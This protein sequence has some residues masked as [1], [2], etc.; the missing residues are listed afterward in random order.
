[1]RT[2]P[3]GGAGGAGLA[4]AALGAT[5]GHP[6][7]EGRVRAR[8]GGPARARG[9]PA[10]RGG[11]PPRRRHLHRGRG[12]GLLEALEGRRAWPRPKPPLPAAVGLRGRPT[13]VQNVE[14][15]CARA[16]GVARSRRVPARARRRSSRCGAHVH[17]PGVYE[18]PLG[19]P[20]R[21]VVDEW[22]GG[23]TDG[24][25]PAVPRR[26]VGSAADRGQADL[27]LDPDALRAAGSGL[28]TAALLVHR[29]RGAAPSAVAASAR[30]RSSSARLRPVPA[31]H[32]RHRQPGRDVRA[33]GGGD[34][35][36]PATCATWPRRPA[37]CRATATARTAARRRPRSAASLAAF[38]EEVPGAHARAAAARA[39]ADAGDPFAAG[40]PERAA[41]EARAGRRLHGR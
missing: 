17:R 21:R 35:A 20:L 16:R 34:G 14:T 11:R 31:L 29:A 30:R 24:H 40:S 33:R 26:P 6:L 2:R 1:M 25:R 39:A 8:G 15:L 32:G 13:L 38:P 41:I 10:A 28:G 12:D 37:S 22:G 5:R 9:A 23:A 19:T 4:A 7:P 36:R 3:G 18:V 27:P